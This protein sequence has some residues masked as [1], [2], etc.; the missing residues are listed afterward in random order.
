MLAKEGEYVYGPGEMEEKRGLHADLRLASTLHL[1]GHGKAVLKP[2]DAPLFA[3]WGMRR[4]KAAPCIFSTAP[5]G[6]L[7]GLTIEAPR[8]T[9]DDH[10][11]VGVGI[12]KGGFRLQSCVISAPK[13]SGGNALLVDG[14][15]AKPVIVGCQ[16][17]GGKDTVQW[18]EGALG[19]LEGC[20]ISGAREAGLA[21][22]DPSTAPLVANNT[23]RDSNWGI[24]IHIDVD[25]AW[26]PGEGNT[27]ENIE[28]EDVLDRRG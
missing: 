5:R 4:K 21:V 17:S 2:A 1:F 10:F 24:Y 6:T 19:R 26:A 16:L 28:E 13:Q 25:A 20:T 9:I 8:G 14:P 22:V 23:F 18:G 27:F 3:A 15:T 12:W 7:D 11:T